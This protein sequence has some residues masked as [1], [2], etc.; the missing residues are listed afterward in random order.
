VKPGY[1]TDQYLSEFISSAFRE[2]VGDGDHSAL[3]SIPENA[4]STAQLL[5]KDNGVLAGVEIAE[6]IFH[7]FDPSLR[8]NI[9]LNDGTRIK[10]GDVAFTVSGSSRSILTTER[11]VLNIMQR[12]SG[13]ATMTRHFVELIAGTNCRLLDTRKTTPNFRLIEKWAVAI[14]GGSNH[15][16]GLFDMIMLKDNHVDMAGG[17]RAAIIRTKDYLRATKRDLKI[18]VETRNLKEVEEV[19]ETGGIDIIMLDNMN[20]E[21]MKE[22]VRLIGGRYKTEAS[23]GIT[24]ETIRDIAL[25]GVDF[26]ST[27][28][29]THSVKSLDLSL[30]ALK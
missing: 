17:I 15:R 20:T 22:A 1:I 4:R 8:L 16:I 24:A 25:C 19:L 9:I 6:K 3:A 28:A 23:G 26:I 2:D 29:L 12:M 5:V 30:K 27:G 10:K 14:G 21:T 18:E 11:L 7:H 13:I